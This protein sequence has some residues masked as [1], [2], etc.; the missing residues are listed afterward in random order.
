[1]EQVG[2]ASNLDVWVQCI[3]QNSGQYSVTYHVQYSVECIVKCRIGLLVVL[4]LGTIY[5]VEIKSC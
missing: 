2:S 5:S 1:M 3:V 4:R